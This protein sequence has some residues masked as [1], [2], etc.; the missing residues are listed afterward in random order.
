MCSPTCE[1]CESANGKLTKVNCCNSETVH[2]WSY[3][4]KAIMCLENMVGFK[5]K[6]V[7]KKLGAYS[8]AQYSQVLCQ[9]L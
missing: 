3:I 1:W 9:F 7:N 8:P 2:F 5:L 6:M 4:N